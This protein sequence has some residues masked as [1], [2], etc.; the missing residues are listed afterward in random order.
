MLRPMGQPCN[1]LHDGENLDILG[2]T[3]FAEVRR[4]IDDESVLMISIRLQ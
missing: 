2:S 1:T 4:Y 3:E